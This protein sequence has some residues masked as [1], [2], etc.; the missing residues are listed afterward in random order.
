[1]QHEGQ[2]LRGSQRFEDHQRCQADRVR[3]EGLLF[4]VDQVLGADDGIG[5]ASLQRLLPPRRA[6]VQ[7]VE[8]HSG[9]HRRQPSP[10]VLHPTRVGAAE[11]EPRFLDGVIRLGQRAEHPVGH[12]PQVGSVL[13]E[14]LRNPVVVLHR[15]HVCVDP[16]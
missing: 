7:H 5:E 3:Q 11:P 13:L 8:A 6:G 12:R 16:S 1:V 10:E 9:H 4:G 15:S 14:P 2:P